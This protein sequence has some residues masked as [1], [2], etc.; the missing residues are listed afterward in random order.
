MCLPMP[1]ANTSLAALVTMASHF[2]TIHHQP[3]PPM[4]PLLTPLANLNLFCYTGLS[5]P[6]SYSF[7]L[8]YRTS[9]DKFALPNGLEAYRR[10]MRLTQ[11]PLSH[12]LGRNG[13]WDLIRNKVCNIVIM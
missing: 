7:K 2:T 6:G 13:P 5:G 12:K 4:P 10:L 1:L 9:S 3:F 11:V 8:V